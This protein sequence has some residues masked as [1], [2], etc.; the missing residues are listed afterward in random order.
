MASGKKT[1][2]I[3]KEQAR[4]RVL[5]I[6]PILRKTYPDATVSLNYKNPLELLIATILAAQCTDARVNIVTAEL[7]KKYRTP[8]DYLKVPLEELA[9]DIR[10]TGFYNNKAKSIQAACRSIIEKFGGK[11]P[12]TMEELLQ[13][14]GVGRKTANVILGNCFGK[15]AIICDTHMLRLAKR[16]GLSNQTDPVK[17]EFELMEIVPKEKYGGWTQFSHCIVFHGR[18][19]CTARKPNCGGCPIARYCPSAGKA[20]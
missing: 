11:V 15:P 10:S 19:C 3:D 4:Q 13:L 8:E 14:N 20:V 18:A 5:K 9:E 6:F 1:A 7:F 17:L 12:E 16:L 2:A